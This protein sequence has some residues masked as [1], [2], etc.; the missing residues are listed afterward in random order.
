MG[1]AAA[2]SSMRRRTLPVW[3]TASKTPGAIA[4]RVVRPPQWWRSAVSHNF[5]AASVEECV[6]GQCKKHDFARGDCVQVHWCVDLVW[7]LE[8]REVVRV[9]VV[10]PDDLSE[11][12]SLR[13]DR[14]AKH[15]AQIEARR[16]C[17]MIAD[18]S[19]EVSGRLRDCS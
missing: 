11:P 16:H 6:E 9:S 10:L 18:G 1:S 12:D 5:P 8:D 2:A 17:H 4:C 3:S 14:E 19:G 13:V 7:L 15:V